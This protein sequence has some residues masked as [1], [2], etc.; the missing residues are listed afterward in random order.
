MPNHLQQIPL[1]YS[2]KVLLQLTVVVRDVFELGE[3]E[4]GR[5]GDWE[6][7]RLGD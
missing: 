2:R 6:T 4:M 7:G 3:R 1:L 5:W